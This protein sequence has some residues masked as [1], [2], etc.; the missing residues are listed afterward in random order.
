M[1][2]FRLEEPLFRVRIL[3]AGS[4]MEKIGVVLSSSRHPCKDGSG[5]ESRQFYFVRCSFNL[6]N[7]LSQPRG[8]L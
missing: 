3:V 4:A 2:N 6:G 7:G 5:P 8:F 1:A